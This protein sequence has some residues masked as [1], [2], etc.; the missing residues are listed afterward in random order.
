MRHPRRFVLVLSCALFFISGHTAPTSVAAGTSGPGVKS[1][2]STEAPSRGDH[3]EKRLPS[4]KTGREND[5]K[6]G[7]VGGGG[8][9]PGGGGGGESGADQVQEELKS[10]A[11][12]AFTYES[13]MDQYLET[14]AQKV[15][16]ALVDKL[17]SAVKDFMK[18]INQELQNAG[19]LQKQE[20]FDLLRPTGRGR[21][22]VHLVM[23]FVLP[24]SNFEE[25]LRASADESIHR[26]Y[27][28]VFDH[29]QLAESL[30]DTEEGSDDLAADAFIQTAESREEKGKEKKGNRV[31]EEKG[32]EKKGNRVKETPRTTAEE[33]K[34]ED[35]VTADGEETL[36]SLSMLQIAQRHL[37][38]DGAVPHPLQAVQHPDFAELFYRGPRVLF[39]REKS[40]S[41]EDVPTVVHLD[42]GPFASV[43]IGPSSPE[44]ERGGRHR[45]FLSLPISQQ[46]VGIGKEPEMF[47]RE[48]TVFKNV[49]GKTTEV[50]KAVDDYVQKDLDD[51]DSDAVHQTV[52]VKDGQ[53][54][55]HILKPYHQMIVRVRR[56]MEKDI[57][58]LPQPDAFDDPGKLPDPG[59]IQP[60]WKPPGSDSDPD[61]GA[62]GDVLVS[63]AGSSSS[64]PPSFLSSASFLQTASSSS[65][66]S[67][68]SSAALRFSHR[69]KRGMSMSRDRGV[70]SSSST[71]RES[72]SRGVEDDGEMPQ[73]VNDAPFAPVSSSP[74]SPLPPSLDSVPSSFFMMASGGEPKTEEDISQTQRGPPLSPEAAPPRGSNSF[75][76]PATLPET[77]SAEDILYSSEL[78]A[79][80]SF[81]ALEKKIL[82]APTSLH[83]Q[84]DTDTS[85][86]NET[87]ADWE[88]SAD[89]VGDE[90]GDEILTGG[91]G[92]DADDRE[93]MG[94]QRESL[95]GSGGGRGRGEEGAFFQTKGGDDVDASFLFGETR[96][97][98]EAARWKRLA[99]KY[100]KLAS[101]N[102][103]QREYERRARQREAQWRASMLEQQAEMRKAAFI[104][105]TSK[106]AETQMSTLRQILTPALTTALRKEFPK[107]HATYS[108]QGA[109][110]FKTKTTRAS[111]CSPFI[112]PS[113]T[114]TTADPSMAR[115]ILP[116]GCRYDL[117][118]AK[119]AGSPAEA[120]NT[121]GT[122]FIWVGCFVP[123]SRTAA[124]QNLRPECSVADSNGA[125]GGSG[126]GAVSSLELSQGIQGGQYE[127]GLV[128]LPDG[129]AWF[130]GA[131]N[132]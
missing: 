111:S 21:Q 87:P 100:S 24:S 112:V 4:V 14:A 11:Q 127:Y 83:Q 72:N 124:E 37:A 121:P 51:P 15:N 10:L 95:R 88:D 23:P 103:E 105:Q 104:Q 18:A 44:V 119:F 52:A 19:S 58:N 28:D 80:P 75:D 67:S 73:I 130:S 12:Q 31:K 22:A 109:K 86:P 84:K 85:G 48:R 16:P 45:M 32:K 118:L 25:Q 93:E 79:K 66:S 36:P 78:E 114:A 125:G 27:T 102:R 126:N 107:Q 98:K 34:E 92:R 94:T 35:K 42:A 20:E 40:S 71:S 56:S 108:L 68:S 5:A 123:L 1:T 115:A 70:S 54:T 7:T 39:P 53:K 13:K 91:G 38:V 64:S 110:V 30:S 116:L 76:A 74:S 49:D 55:K 29:S 43:N 9:A 90:A 47:S 41:K 122:S 60:Q 129:R 6:G 2:E 46:G 77:P 132:L 61:P 99:V 81:S 89:A 69:R 82:L 96:Q 59:E 57:D 97:E 63:P 101:R 50:L 131:L 17:K 3:L 62:P 106:M 65:F 128:R 113:S 8:G 117:L 26:Q 120:P 33:K